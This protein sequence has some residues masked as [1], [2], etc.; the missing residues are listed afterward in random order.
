VICEKNCRLNLMFLNQDKNIRYEL[1][2]YDFKNISYF[3]ALRILKS[4]QEI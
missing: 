2:F 1:I 4:V 3:H